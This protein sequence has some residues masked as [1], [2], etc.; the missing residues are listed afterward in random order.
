M[1]ALPTNQNK[2]SFM[3][4][5]IT[6]AGLLLA[7]ASV[8]AQA[9]PIVIKF[10]HVVADDTPKGKG[11]LMFKR[12]AEERLPGQVRVEVYPNS[13]LFGDATELEALRNDEVQ[14]L[15]PSLAKF[16]QYTKQLQVFDLPFLFDDIE[17][18][19][20]FQKR[21]KGKQ[22]LR[23]MEDKNITGLAYWHN[24]MKQLSATRML[25]QPSDA[26]GLSFRIQP[27]AVLEAQFGTVGAS[28]QKIPFADVYDALRAGTVQ[29]AENPWSNIYSKRMHTVQPYIVETDHG[30]LDYMVVSNTRFWMGMPHKIRF[31]L[32]AI[33]DEVSFMVN[34]EAEELNRADRERIRQAGTSEIVALTP[35]ER[36][37]WREAMRP[38]WQQFEPVIGADIIKAAET[39]NRK[40]R[41]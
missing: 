41:N 39:V 35:E 40:Q 22:L 32:E 36:E 27:S 16:E 11:A 25:R 8:C 33:L 2:E 12:L 21:A 17:A 34:R 10:S 6:L 23:S 30:V 38:V 24:G 3:K 37:G 20:R 9:E 18:V 13:T 5:I 14:L 26:S 7:V 19:N 15:A 29:G 28:T 1:D 31:E 4:P